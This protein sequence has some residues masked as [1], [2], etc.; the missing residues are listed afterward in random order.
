MN[1]TLYF[2]VNGYYFE[3]QVDEHQAKY[4]FFTIAI[5]SKKKKEIFMN[6][7]YW[8]VISNQFVQ[9]LWD[10]IYVERI[11]FDQTLFLHRFETIFKEKL[12]MVIRFEG[13]GS[14][15]TDHLLT[16]QNFA[17]DGEG[18]RATRYAFC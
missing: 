18:N 2:I 16:K 6:F 1:N 15:F 8:I 7:D 13:V 5:G 11:A 9:I 10:R 17:H 14:A 4:I 12:N 3:Y